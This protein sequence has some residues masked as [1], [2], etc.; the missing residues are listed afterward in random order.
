[1]KTFFSLLFT[2]AFIGN[3][4]ATNDT[5]KIKFRIIGFEVN[6]GYFSNHLN[7]YT[8]IPIA[9]RGHVS[10]ETISKSTKWLSSNNRTGAISYLKSDFTI[11][12][13]KLSLGYYNFT[14]V[15]YSSDLFRILMQGNAQFA[16]E[17]AS[18]GEP[19]PLRMRQ[20]GFI[21]LGYFLKHKNIKQKWQLDF[22]PEIYLITKSGNARTFG[23]N[24][25]FTS[26]S[27]LDMTATLNYRYKPTGGFGIRGVGVGVSGLLY[28]R[29]KAKAI[30][31]R[32]DNLGVGLITAKSRELYHDTIW[33]YSGLN[34]A[35]P[36]NFSN[37]NIE[38]SIN[39]LIA[40][41]RV[42][43]GGIIAIPV[44]IDIALNAEK[45]KL[46]V[47]YIGIT[48]FLP[49]IYYSRKYYHKKSIIGIGV[50]AGGW[51]LINSKIELSRELKSET[52]QKLN[53]QIIGIESL[54]FNYPSLSLKMGFQ[55]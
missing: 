16:G 4:S 51:G 7:A 3:L 50:Q 27:G 38:D 42:N 5:G 17:T 33:N 37:L 53:L 41:E 29:I 46:G 24:S 8:V 22:A 25:L 19:N 35:E 15:C 18:F 31:V 30:T 11:N 9:S 34:A 45:Y 2:L 40:K 6:A 49:Q 13:Q 10:S 14:G 52:L 20:T 54:M 39:T 32:I 55:W 44:S 26:E 47:Q 23:T 21:K 48:G 1:M 28:R 43:K 12:K 36:L